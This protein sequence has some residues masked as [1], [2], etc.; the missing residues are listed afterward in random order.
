L[1]TRK[2]LIRKVEDHRGK[3]QSKL[4]EVQE[5]AVQTVMSAK[6]MEIRTLMLILAL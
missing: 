5:Q 3:D 4:K 2:D 6:T 1:N